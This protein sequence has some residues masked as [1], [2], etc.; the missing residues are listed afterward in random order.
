M[1]DN[2]PMRFGNPMRSRPR[3]SFGRFL[4][5]APAV[6]LALFIFLGAIPPSAFAAFG[7][8][9]PTA[10]GSDPFGSQSSSLRV[11]GSTGAY[12]E[13]ISITVPPG[14]NG[15]QPSLSLDYNSQNTLDSMVGYGWSLSIPYIS[16]LN[17]TGTQDLYT[18]PTYVSSLD[19][20]LAQISTTTPG[21]THRPRV[22]TTSNAYSFSGNTWT[23][24]DKKGARYTFGSS[25][26]GRQYDT[27][28]SSANTYKWMIQE[29]RDTNDNYVTFTYTHDSNEIYPV[30]IVYTGHGSI[31]GPFSV[32]FATST[33]SDVREDY[34]P[35]FK[36]TTNWRISEIDTS[37]SGNLAGKYTLSYG[38]GSN[39]V[40][41]IL[42]S[43]QQTGY[44]ESGTG[45]TLPAT[46]FSYEASTAPF[47]TQS[48]TFSGNG[49]S[50]DGPSSIVAEVSVWLVICSQPLKAA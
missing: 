26:G 3:T 18:N 20:E 7:D 2:V 37:I 31:D 43:I 19:G 10:F 47:I 27:A 11:D 1:F 13:S 25:D 9:S 23:M 50:S 45:T 44:D 34:R 5:K 28:T 17:K 38:T 4:S 33:R 6:L 29:I 40:R 46:S 48:N 16:R 36:V 22:D 15:L 39:G 8:A 32:T 21:I 35:G 12:T 49:L 41:S 30:S 24:Y 14:R 42:T